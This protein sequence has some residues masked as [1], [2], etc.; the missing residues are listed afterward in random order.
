MQFKQYP[1]VPMS[2]QFEQMEDSL[3]SDPIAQSS[4]HVMEDQIKMLYRYAKERSPLFLNQ[5][6]IL[7]PKF[8]KKL[9]KRAPNLILSEMEL[10]AYSKLR[11]GNQEIAMSTGVSVRAVESRKYR[12]RKKL[13]LHRDDNFMLW[14]MDL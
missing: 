6:N 7:Y 5:F 8:A 3:A 9:L 11:Y 10:C 14:I 1:N 4:A 13:N 2:Y 12:V